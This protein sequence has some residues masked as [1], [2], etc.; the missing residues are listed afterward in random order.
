V[1]RMAARGSSGSIRLSAHIFCPTTDRLLHYEALGPKENSGCY[2][3]F[4]SVITKPNG[5]KPVPACTCEVVE[6]LPLRIS[7]RVRRWESSSLFNTPRAWTNR[8]LKIVSCHT[9]MCESSTYSTLNQRSSLE[10]LLKTDLHMSLIAR[11]VHHSEF[12]VRG[13][14]RD[15]GMRRG[16]VP[17]SERAH[18]EPFDSSSN[19][20]PACLA[21]D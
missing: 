2:S 3:K 14:M 7:R 1:L 16:I 4:R 10:V 6:C 13:K 19:G 5:L 9:L 21:R 20:Q 8:L 15:L 18:V 17:S 11:R 12:S